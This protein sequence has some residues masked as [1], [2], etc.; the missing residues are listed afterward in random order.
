MLR[1]IKDAAKIN[2]A[3]T[4]KENVVI[5]GSGFIGM[6]LAGTLIR[7]GCQ[8]H[9][10]SMEDVPFQLVLGKEVGAALLKWA[11]KKGLKFTPRSTISEI[12]LDKNG[13]VNGVKCAKLNTELKADVVVFA[14][15]GIPTTSMLNVDKERDGGVRVSPWLETSAKDLYAAGDIATGSAPDGSAHRVEHYDAAFSQGR[16]AAKIML[17]PRGVDDTCERDVPFFWTVV[18]G[19]T[20]KYTGNSTNH[21]STFCDGD[22]DKLNFVYYYFKEDEVIAVCTMSRDPLISVVRKLMKDGKMPKK[23]DI[24][25]KG[26]KSESLIDMVRKDASESEQASLP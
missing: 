10:C 8:V 17:N 16:L 14:C 24:M 23:Q 1:S 13:K 7:K 9:T 21:D 22:L 11:E 4:Q 5:I 12:T 3:T 6:E 26:F 15:G 20:V 25:K 19:Q 2:A 18:C